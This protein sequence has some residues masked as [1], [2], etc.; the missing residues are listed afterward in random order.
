MASVFNKIIEIDTV[1][2]RLPAG[3][4]ILLS[5]K[6]GEKFYY[7]GSVQSDCVFHQEWLK[8]QAVSLLN[9]AR[10]PTMFWGRSRF[11]ERRYYASGQTS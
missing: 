2:L 4:S 7:A 11:N 3:V 5:A 9:M 1:T 10:P 6:H 8:I